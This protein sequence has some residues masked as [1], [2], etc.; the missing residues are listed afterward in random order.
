LGIIESSVLRSVSIV[1]EVIGI[2]LT[3]GSLLVGLNERFASQIFIFGRFDM[4]QHVFDVTLHTFGLVYILQF[5]EQV[6][7]HSA[8]IAI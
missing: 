3:C 7:G 4:S 2:T 5:L 6:D 8:L 1:L